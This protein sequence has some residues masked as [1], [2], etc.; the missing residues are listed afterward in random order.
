MSRCF[1]TQLYILTSFLSWL[2]STF[3]AELSH[4]EIL[5][6][7]FKGMTTVPN[8]TT[9]VNSTVVNSTALVNT[10]AAVSTTSINSTVATATTIINTTTAVPSVMTQLP[11]LR[12]PNT[13]GE[14][15]EGGGGT[16][17]AGVCGALFVIGFIAV[18]VIYWK[19]YQL[20]AEE[21]ARRARRKLSSSAGGAPFSPTSSD[22]SPM[23]SK[24]AM[25]V[26]M[27]DE[28]PSRGSTP[29][30]NAIAAQS[31]SFRVPSLPQSQLRAPPTYDARTTSS[32]DADVSP[33][34]RK[35][36]YFVDSDEE[37]L[38]SAR[39]SN[40]ARRVQPAVGGARVHVSSVSH[41]NYFDM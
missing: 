41:R 33:L 40:S 9:L 37:L 38:D 20:Q 3:V 32:I 36:S 28:N 16:W 8:A 14:L 6:S 29:E 25:D 13:A 27:F 5:F 26:I 34:Q 10:T 2:D 19:N 4:V 31:A 18:A 17:A 21:K 23:S 11:L 12:L 7:S 30:F 15:P 39:R 35:Q 24:K 22:G 1:H